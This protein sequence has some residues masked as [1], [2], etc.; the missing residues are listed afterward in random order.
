MGQATAN[1][2]DYALY[3]L[4]LKKLKYI[5]SNGF[6]LMDEVRY[7]Y[8]WDDKKSKNVNKRVVAQEDAAVKYFIDRGIIIGDRIKNAFRDQELSARKLDPKDRVWANW[9]EVDTA[10]REYEYVV[11]IRGINAD[12]F[13][14]QLE[15]FD[16]VD[17]PT[18][19]TENTAIPKT[20]PVTTKFGHFTAHKD[21]SIQFNNRYIK[22]KPEVRRL[23]HA[24]ISQKGKALK[25]EQILDILW[26]EETDSQ[27]YLDNPTRT[28]SVIKKR[29]G[30]IASEANVAL[31][32]FSDKKHLVSS[33]ETSYKL[34]D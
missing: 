27:K 17:T 13:D 12:K 18:G 30:N 6:F 10:Y 22:V 1:T 5:L 28:K 7:E 23:V 34:V 31:Q 26:S 24:L 11:F 21:G 32:G 9:S 14:A 15:L 16:L 19:L 2:V 20:S 3:V 25:Y 29:I 33:G 8:S 4:V